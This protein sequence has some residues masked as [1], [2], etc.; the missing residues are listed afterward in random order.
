MLVD[1][2]CHLDFPDFA[3]ELD[4]VVDR[5]RQAGIGRMVTI[6]THL[7]RF[8]RVAAVA[9]RFDDVYCSLG[10]HPHQAAEEDALLTV[11]RLV[12][13][14]AHPKVVGLGETGLDYFYDK[15]PRDVQQDCF[16]RHIRAAL[17]TG[18]P[19][20]IHTRDADDDTMR[21]VREEAAGRPVTGL[22]HC[23]SSGRQL[24]EEALDFG[25]HLSLSGIVTFKK[26]DD[27]RAIVKDVPLD[28]I[29]VETDAPYLAP[30]PHRGRR[31]EPAFTALTAACVAEV[32]GVDPTELARRTTDN[33]FRLF[34]RADRAARGDARAAA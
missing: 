19:L 27:L 28:R 31:N 22:L 8:E 18:L 9:E 17:E 20:I 21:I 30:V 5:A 3:E 14:S 15:S 7:S 24:A 16:R 2:H 6:C 32:K 1:S 10:V 11:E 13:L 25:F 23:F 26:S 34:T 29:L 12:E 33:F 4:A